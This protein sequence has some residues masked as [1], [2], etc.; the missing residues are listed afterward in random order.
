YN[1]KG[2]LVF[3]GKGVVTYCET[4]QLV[5]SLMQ[6]GAGK[7]VS[8]ETQTKWTSVM[9]GYKIPAWVQPAV[10]YGLENSI[11][12][13]SDI[14]GFVNKNGKSVNAT[15]QDV[16]IIFGR[17]MKDYGT[18]NPG[19]SLSFKDASSINA[20][21]VPYV[22][23]LNRL[24]VISGDTDGNYNP[25]STINRAEMAVFV[26][27]SYDVIK[28]GATTS[29]NN[30]T[31]NNNNSIINPVQT[32]AGSMTGTIT[33]VTPIGNSTGITLD[34]GSSTKS[35]TGASTTPVLSG[36]TRVAISTL[37]VG[38]K[39]LVSYNGQDLVSVLVTTKASDNKTNTS[40]SSSD[41]T[42]TYVD[43][44]SSYIK[45][46]VNGSTKTYNY[47]KD[48]YYYTSFYIDDSTSTYSKFRDAVGT[49]KTIRLVLDSNDKISK[50]YIEDGLSG[51]FVSMTKSGIKIKINDSTKSYYY[52]D[53]KYDDVTFRID[54][55]SSTYSRVY[56]KSSTSYTV[57]LKLDS[58]DNVKEV[59]LITKNNGN[60]GNFVSMTKRGIRVKVNGS[61]KSYDFVD[62]DE[63]NVRFKIDGSSSTYSRVDDRAS[64]SHTVKLTFD[65]RDE[66]KEVDLITKDND[67]DTKFTYL[68]IS[69]TDIEVKKNGSSTYYK[70]KGDDR[71]EVDFSVDGDDS[72][73]SKVKRKA[74]TGDT[75]KLTFN[76]DDRVTKVNLVQNGD[77]EDEIKGT[78]SSIAED[79]IRIKPS[80]RSSTEK[81]YF[82]DDR[83]SNV[84][85]YYND[86]SKKYSYIESNAQSGDS[87]KLE[88]DGDEVTAVYITS[89][90]AGDVSGRLSY[91][92]SSTVRVSGD[93]SEYKFEDSDD[94]EVDVEDGRSR[95]LDDYDD[96]RE[97]FDD[98]KKMQ[99]G[100]TINRDDEVIEIEGYVYEVEGTVELVS[101]SDNIIKV[102]T[103][104][105]S[106]TYYLDSSVTIENSG[107]YSNTIAG[108]ASAYTDKKD[109]MKVTLKLNRNGYVD[110]VEASF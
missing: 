54:G 92:S 98:G 27:K 4:M 30:T 73:Y 62:S 23:L 65:S 34:D 66:V 8:A 78:F 110:K 90:G 107:S 68:S 6:K 21:A 15:R 95:T 9:N 80:S 96:L 91:L 10:A 7:S 67:S 37:A 33:A 81:Y 83:Y 1:D 5:Y 69:S 104:S 57:K 87:V 101:P 31:N 102:K 75:I 50:A 49:D 47:I 19:A 29:N 25:R 86:S 93:S 100:I 82:D 70:F 26:S 108:L 32:E 52:K 99:I 13:I 22:D 38:D 63:E 24:G 40:T 59:D 28:S 3:R 76:S 97:A 74:E 51:K 46:K 56:D 89:D 103:R 44:S 41:I 85:F 18:I 88:L 43:M 58:R 2:K 60:D 14:P 53:D 105:R 42:G 106:V 77:G 35:F 55:S 39:I 16:A 12:T 11:V 94:C 72:T 71:S 84:S 79:Y 36:S 17:A 61:T 109:N 45:V 64:S 48:D 20:V